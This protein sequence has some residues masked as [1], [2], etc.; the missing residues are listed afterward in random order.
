MMYDLKALESAE[1][2]TDPFAFLV[3]EHFIDLPTTS[4]INRD[5]PDIR[6]P[7]NL[8]LEQLDCRGTFQQFVE[9]LASEELTEAMSR[10]FDVD[11]R[12]KPIQITVRGL[13]EPRDGKIHTD[14]KSKIVTALMYFNDEWPH[15][16]GRLRMLR[17]GSDIEDYVAEV[18]PLSGTLLAFRR[19]DCSFHGHKPFDGA[20]R[21]IQLS[22]VKPKRLANYQRKRKKITWQIRRLLHLD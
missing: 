18:P 11:L 7:K 14:S 13:C 16:G 5:Y 1:L 10:K 21:M 8:R 3:L 9:T 19:S 12:G 2:R 4:L 17:S 20:R 22:W 6:V 15:E